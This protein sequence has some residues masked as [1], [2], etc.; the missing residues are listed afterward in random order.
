[1]SKTI[2]HLIETECKLSQ[3]KYWLKAEHHLTMEEFIILYRFNG[4][5][6]ITGKVLRDTLHY[7]MKWNTSKIDVLI[8]KLY[9][10]EL[11]AKERSETDERQVFYLL[12]KTQREFVASVIKEFETFAK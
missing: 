8:R 2:D 7:D 4:T 11:I 10:R 3:I 9:K 5:D 6:K 12:D 1:M